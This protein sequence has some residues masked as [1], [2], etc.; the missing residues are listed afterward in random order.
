MSSVI[1]FVTYNGCWHETNVYSCKESM[2]ILVSMN[3]SYVGLLEIL[4]EALELNPEMYTLRIK[5]IFKVDYVPVKILNNRGKF[6]YLELK[7]N[8]PDK[9]KFA[10][11]VDIIRESISMPNEVKLIVT[12]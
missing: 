10:L 11:S 6:F 1:V 4:F 9:T 7:K 8:E 12:L 5:Y 2:G 3:M